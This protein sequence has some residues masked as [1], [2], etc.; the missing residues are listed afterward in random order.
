MVWWHTFLVLIG[1]GV[2]L[3]LMVYSIRGLSD[4]TI[5]TRN[6]TQLEGAA[7]RRYAIPILIIGAIIVVAGVWVM[8]ATG[9]M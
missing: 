2:G 9:S 5:T 8:F 4:G 3:V 1:T 7:A 6:G